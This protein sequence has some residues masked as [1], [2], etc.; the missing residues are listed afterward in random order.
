MSSK[1]YVGV[2]AFP[3]YVIRT[4]SRGRTYYYFRRRSFPIVRLPDEPGSVPFTTA[5]TAALRATNLEEFTALRKHMKKQ[6]P[7]RPDSPNTQAILIWAERQPLTLAQAT[8]VAQRFG[9]SVDE[10][11]GDREIVPELNESKK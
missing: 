3:R 8:L 1:T 5:Y 6:R 4:Q 11:T 2:T 10:I 7:R 9:V